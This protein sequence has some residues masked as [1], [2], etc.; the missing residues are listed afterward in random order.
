MPAPADSPAVAAATT[1]FAKIMHWTAV[2]HGWTLT[3]SWREFV[4]TIGSVTSW[5]V[6]E[7][8]ELQLRVFV[9]RDPQNPVDQRPGYSTN[10]GLF[11]NW[12]A[13]E[14]PTQ[15]PGLPTMHF[16]EGNL[17]LTFDFRG[18]RT[19]IL[20]WNGEAP[21]EAP[22]LPEPRRSISLDP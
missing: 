3:W 12:V 15:S 13:R 14:Q 1:I 10:V 11:L 6:T 17:D 5:E 16:D 21:N 4:T 20:L 9:I 7:H 8:C 19:R 2:N 18:W 22:Q